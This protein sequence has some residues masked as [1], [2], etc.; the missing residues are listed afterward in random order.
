MP[1]LAPPRI[2]RK[3]AKAS[4]A[5]LWRGKPSRWDFW[6]HGVTSSFLGLFRTCLEQTRLQYVEGWSKRGMPLAIEFGSCCHW[7]LEQAYGGLKIKP[8][9]IPTEDWVK[10]WV[11][12]YARKLLAETPGAT[13]KQREQ[14]ELV[15]GLAQTVMPVYF[16]RWGG[17]F[18]GKYKYAVGQGLATPVKWKSLEEVFDIPYTFPDGRVTHIRGRRDGV[19]L[20]QKGTEWVF[21]TKCRSV[22]IEDDLMDML[23]FD[24]QQMLYTH[25]TEKQSGRMPA[26]VQMNIIRR[27]GQRR[28]QGESLPSLLARVHAEVS[29]PKRFDHYFIRHQMALSKGDLNDWRQKVL[30]PLMATVRMWWEGNLPHHMNDM[31]LTTKYGRCAMF[32]PITKGDFSDCFRRPHIFAELGKV[33]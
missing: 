6:Q 4:S 19:F 22:I 23:P 9:Q 1:L 15:Y 29:K 26:G 33:N 18:S 30:H 2:V 8:R 32:L 12:A 27:P 16:E 13:T 28:L 11:S 17:D 21:D 5:A 10:A 20:S 14:Q 25:V 31:N 24:L 7:I 3:A